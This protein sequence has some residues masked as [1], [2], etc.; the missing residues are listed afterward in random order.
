MLIAKG[1]SAKAL[2]CVDAPAV[3]KP[4]AIAAVMI[5]TAHFIA[6]FSGSGS[7]FIGLLR[8]FKARSLSVKIDYYVY[9][10]QLFRINYRRYKRVLA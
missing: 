2:E 7:G 10:F 8:I 9:R 5:N 1:I 4:K 3:E 6:V